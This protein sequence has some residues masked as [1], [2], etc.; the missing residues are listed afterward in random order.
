MIC[1][2]A[3]IWTRSDPCKPCEDAKQLLS[4]AGIPYTERVVDERTLTREHHFWPKF[5]KQALFPQI[6]LDGRRIGGLAELKREL[7]SAG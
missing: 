1:T 7:S 4:L 5:G 6:I 3:V 2:T